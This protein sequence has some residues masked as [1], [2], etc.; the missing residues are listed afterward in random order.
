MLPRRLR[1]QKGQGAF[2]LVCDLSLNAKTAQYLSAKYYRRAEGL[3]V[4]LIGNTWYVH[5]LQIILLR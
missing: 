3:G 4:K 1:L 2:S 5:L